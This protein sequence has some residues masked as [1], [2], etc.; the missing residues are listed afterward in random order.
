MRSPGQEP[1]RDGSP[2]DAAGAACPWPAAAW[3][4]AVVGPAIDPIALPASGHL[5]IGRG[6]ECAARLAHEGISRAHL[7]ITATTSGWSAR[8]VGSTHGT[9]IDG[10]RIAPHEDVAIGAGSTLTVGP[11]VFRVRHGESDM[12]VKLAGPQRDDPA[13]Q[14]TR[15]T[16]FL[17]LQAEDS[18]QRELS[19]QEFRDRYAPVIVGVARHAG[20]SAD[21]ADDVL[22]D[23]LL[24][25]FQVSPRFEYDP[26]KG[27]FRGYLKRAALNV[28]RRRRRRAAPRSLAH[29]PADEEIEDPHLSSGW[30]AAWEAQIMERALSEVRSHVD[31]RTWE[32]FELYV[33][34]SMPAEEVG[35]RLGLSANSVHQ[36]KSRVLRAA[37]EFADRLLHE[38][39]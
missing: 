24:A 4:D 2:A 32:A 15:A 9:Q 10:V 26:S 13:A 12:P 25:F 28:I 39:G 8:D 18:R 22:Q 3:L 33:T 30:D 38:E 23:V 27:R 31:P 37:R 1:P 17:R 16:I 34:R 36:A 14:A 19:W 35:A 21:E 6:E 11:W 7:R 20:L 29:D 5:L